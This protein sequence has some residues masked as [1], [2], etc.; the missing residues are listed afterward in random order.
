MLLYTLTNMY[1][2]RDS[3]R[4]NRIAT[5]FKYGYANVD[6][7]AEWSNNTSD[8]MDV[9][10]EDTSMIHFVNRNNSVRFVF[11]RSRKN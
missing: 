10:P 7:I 3:N 6:T 8:F 1:I 11:M 2:Q 9:R 4:F 5:G